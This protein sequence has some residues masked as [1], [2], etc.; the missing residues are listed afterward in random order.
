MSTPEENKA[1]VRRFLDEGLAGQPEVFDE[2]CSPDFVNH[3]APNRRGG[4][5]GLKDVIAYSLR[6]QPDQ[7]WAES[8]LIA[9][10]DLVVLYGTR[11]ATWQGENFRGFPT[12]QG[13]QISVELAHLFRI[14]DGKITEHWAVRDD[15]G[16]LLQV[17]ALTPPLS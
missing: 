10:G 16:M 1:L 4:V 8:F 15:L 6:V 9:D 11:E 7:R 17:G 5:Q 12:P 3:A 13:E 14:I 2:I